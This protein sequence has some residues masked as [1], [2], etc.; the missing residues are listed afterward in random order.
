MWQWLLTSLAVIGLLACPHQCAAK[1][2]AARS[3]ANV[4][5]SGCTCCNRT[6]CEDHSSESSIPSPEE[7][8][9]HCI[10]DGVTAAVSIE[11]VVDLSCSFAGFIREAAPISPPIHAVEISQS[12]RLFAVDPLRVGWSVRIA[13]R[14]ILL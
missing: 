5:A 2:S 4:D 6:K 12:D 9:Q 10:C 14:S 13:L 8:G 3:L 1:A 7:D 11:S